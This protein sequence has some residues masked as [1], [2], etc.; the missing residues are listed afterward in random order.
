MMA[1]MGLL[2]SEFNFSLTAW[3]TPLC[4]AGHLPHTGGDRVAA[5]HC[6]SKRPDNLA[7]RPSKR[8][9][10]VTDKNLAAAAWPISPRVGEMPGRAE[11]GNATCKARLAETIQTA[12]PAQ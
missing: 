5:R 8:H 9:S 6:L 11:G 12:G 1:S 4:P 3:G 2:M 7:A 10:C